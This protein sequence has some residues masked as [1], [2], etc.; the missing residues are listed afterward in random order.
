M[1]G[2]PKRYVTKICNQIA[3]VSSIIRRGDWN[4]VCQDWR[5]TLAQAEVGDFTYVDPPYVGRHTGYFD[6]WSDEVKLSSWQLH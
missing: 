3:W 1:S 6:L 5:M 4:F 2:L